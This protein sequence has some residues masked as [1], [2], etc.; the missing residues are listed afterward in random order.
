MDITKKNIEEF[1]QNNIKLF[2][3]FYQRD[4]NWTNKE[5]S[6]LLEDVYASKTKN[7]YIGSIVLK[8]KGSGK[9]IIDGQQ[10]I[11]TFWLILRVIYENKEILDSEIQGKIEFLMNY[12]NFS[13]SNF[14]DGKILHKIVKGEISL[15]G[16][17]VKESNYYKNYVFI[18][19][20]IDKIKYSL[21]DFWNQF[22]KVIVAEV[23][24]DA[25][26]DEHTLFAQINSTGKRLTAYDLVKNLLFSELTEKYHRDNLDSDTVENNINY[27]LELLHSVVSYISTDKA[28]NELIRYFISYKTGSLINTDER[29]LYESFKLLLLDIDVCPESL[30]NE[31]FKF[32]SYY[33]LFKNNEFIT[34]YKTLNGPL[35]TITSSLN[36]YLVL[37]IDI[38]IKNTKFREGQIIEPQLDVISKA[39]LILEAYKFRR[40][41]QGASE[42]NITRYIPAL[43]KK[44]DT[45]I[46]PYDVLLYYLIYYVPNNAIKEATYKMPTLKEFE[47]G[48][49][50]T[51]V[52]LLSSNDVK[53]FIWRL[54][55]SIAKETYE[56][57]DF[58]VEHVLPQKYVKWIENGY[59]EDLLMVENKMHTIGNLTLTSYNPELSN[60][61]FS[62]K[63][64]LLKKRDNFILNKYFLDLPDWN[65]SEIEKRANDIYS[66]TNGLWDFS[67]Y[68]LKIKS[69]ENELKIIWDAEIKDKQNFEKKILHKSKITQ[70]IKHFKNISDKISFENIHIA[71][72]YYLVDG[73]SQ[74]ETEGLAFGRK[75]DGWV[76]H[77]ILD[78]LEIDAKVT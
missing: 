47:E 5:V 61:I 57:T 15:C 8:N 10:R 78:Y 51:K 71:L 34:K 12:F 4:Y 23:C 67:S 69:K 35:T 39:L 37:L 38:F 18:K 46:L 62:V 17:N 30:F 6:E 42:K 25:D 9:S 77:S 27:K 22:T 70:N 58:T 63:K 64:D 52:Y 26:V 48:M 73:L 33:K 29:K 45:D 74:T 11:S 3:P 59:N 41:F 21:T 14:K 50:S 68:D 16:D 66:K 36:T 2:V 53:M 43:C 13:S 75:S 54:A 60:E 7:Y 65:L 1:L 40:F 19:S 32:A 56:L 20:W 55:S 44:M 31:F 49:H 76:T 24:L 72:K 28:Y